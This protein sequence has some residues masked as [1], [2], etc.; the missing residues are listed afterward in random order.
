MPH[1]SIKLFI[2]EGIIRVVFPLLGVALLVSGLLGTVSFGVV[3]LYE[4]MRSRQWAP[5]PATIESVRVVPARYLRNRPLPALDVRF[6]FELE[7]VSFVGTRYDL[8]QGFDLQQEL[9]ATLSRLPPGADVT[10]WVSSSAPEQAMLQRSLNWSLLWLV[11]PYALL[12]LLGGLFLLGGMV[13]WNE[14]RPLR[15]RVAES[16]ET[17]SPPKKA[18]KKA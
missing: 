3:P 17:E 13:A 8:Q 11:L 6:R 9:E 16:R 10:A 1:V 12:S 5:V 7:G 4:A 15:S 2:L 18:A 14:A